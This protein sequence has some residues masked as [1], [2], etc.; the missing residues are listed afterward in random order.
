MAVEFGLGEIE[1]YL[2]SI[3]ADPRIT[4]D[5]GW[6]ARHG[7]E[8]VRNPDSV[9][10]H[11]ERLAEAEDTASLL[12]AIKEAQ[13]CPSEFDVAKLG[14]FKL[15]SGRANKHLWDVEC[16]TELMKL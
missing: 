13:T 11:M 5:E 1:D 4:N 15:K 2:I 9:A 3:G 7:I 14:Q 6:E 10:Y 8:G 12:E 16:K